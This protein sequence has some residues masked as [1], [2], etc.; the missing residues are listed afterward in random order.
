MFKHVSSTH[1][2]GILTSMNMTYEKKV[3]FSMLSFIEHCL[4][5]CPFSLGNCIVN[6]SLIYGV[7]LSLWYLQTVSQPCKCIL[8][9]FMGTRWPEC[10]SSFTSDHV[11]NN[12][13][14]RVEEL[15]RGLSSP[16]K[17][18]SRDNDRFLKVKINTCTNN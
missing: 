1:E 14:R 16:I 4:S 10:L 8:S 17:S 6:D 7:W 11:S 15:Y 5:L 2:N 9:L 18:G 3:I 12:Q 13:W